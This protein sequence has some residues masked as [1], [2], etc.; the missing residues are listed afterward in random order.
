MIDSL[1][2]TNN[3]LEEYYMATENLLDSIFVRYCWPDAIDSYEYYKSI[4]NIESIYPKLY[5]YME[6]CRHN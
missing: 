1:V 2:V 3:L 4:E 5:N 6:E